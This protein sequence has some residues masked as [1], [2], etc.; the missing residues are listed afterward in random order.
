LFGI[1]LQHLGDFF[2]KIKKT[3]Q[4]NF[5]LK[6][7]KNKIFCY[8]Y[9]SV[10]KTSPNEQK[11]AKNEHV[12][13][14]EHCD[15]TSCRKNNY[16]R[17]LSSKKHLQKA[18]PKRHQTSRKMQKTSRNITKSKNKLFVCNICNKKYKSRNGLW[19]HNKKCKDVNQ[20]TIIESNKINDNYVKI[21]EKNIEL[22]EKII[23]QQQNIIDNKTQNII[24][25]NGDTINNTQNISIN[26]FLNEY[27]KDAMNLTDFVDNLKVTIKDMHRTNKLGLVDGIT[28]IFLDGLNDISAVK[29]PIHCVDK[30]RG[31]FYIKDDN[32]WGTN[33]NHKIQGAMHNVKIKHIKKLKE[34]EDNHPY[35]N[36]PG[37]PNNEPWTKLVDTVTKDVEKKE[38]N[39]LLKKIQDSVSFKETVKN[40]NN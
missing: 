18:S 10:T 3:P 2:K 24:N 32:K 11:N 30:K 17:H 1:Y 29:R 16:D 23:N 36:V 15:Y 9:M 20:V 4:R 33:K 40:I 37:H 28:N 39:T 12:F 38:Q 21:L 7:L 5:F 34:W 14:C 25:N 35:F 6:K 22:Q 31:K 26:V 19:M 27:C 13:F 8:I